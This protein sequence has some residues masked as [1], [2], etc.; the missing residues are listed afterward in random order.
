MFGRFH[1]FAMSLNEL[2]TAETELGAAAV[3][4]QSVKCVLYY[5]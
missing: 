3:H 2:L 1:C 5:I 4:N